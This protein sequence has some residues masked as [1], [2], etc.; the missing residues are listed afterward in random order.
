MEGTVFR[1]VLGR[2][3]DNG[4]LIM[5]GLLNAITTEAVAELKQLLGPRTSDARPSA[6]TT[7]AASPTIFPHRPTSSAFRTRRTRSLAS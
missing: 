5:A 3:D 1:P 2:H 6:I 7:A 4:L